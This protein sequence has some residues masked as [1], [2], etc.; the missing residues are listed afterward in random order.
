MTPRVDILYCIY[1]SEE[2]MYNHQ[3]ITHFPYQT[4]VL[5]FVPL[6]IHFLHIISQHASAAATLAT[7]AT[8]PQSLASVSARRPTGERRTAQ[9]ARTGTTGTQTADPVTVSP[10]ELCELHY[11]F[12]SVF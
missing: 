4:I 12:P 6:P 3:F 9:S 1:D 11:L 10:M 5:P 7:P 2:Y 8:A